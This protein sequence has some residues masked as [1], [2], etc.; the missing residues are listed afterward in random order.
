MTRGILPSRITLKEY[1]ENVA[2]ATVKFDAEFPVDSEGYISVPA[3]TNRDVKFVLRNPQQYHLYIKMNFVNEDTED[4][5]ERGQF[6]TIKQNEEDVSLL[7]MTI[8]SAFL[9]NHDGGGD[10]SSLIYMTEPKSG[11]TFDAYKF[12]LRC[13]TPPDMYGAIVCNLPVGDSVTN[14]VLCFNL[15]KTEFLKAGATHSDINCV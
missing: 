11:R 5:Y 3:Y 7:N 2:V 9:K 12:A 4:D 15:P 8:T 14:Y 6:P 13:N 1:T 10:V